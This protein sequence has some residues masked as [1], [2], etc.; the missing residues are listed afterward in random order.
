MIK[1]YERELGIEHKYEFPIRIIA[2]IEK[3][4]AVRNIDE[5]IEATDGVMVA[6]GDL[7]IEMPA[8]DVPLIQKT[9]IDKCLEA[10]K[11]VVVATQMLDSMIRNPRPTRAEVSDI[12]NAVIDHTDAIMLSGETA[13]GKH[14]VEAVATMAT[15]AMETEASVY[16]D[17]DAPCGVTLKKTTEDAISEVANILVRGIKAKLILVASMSGDTARIVS[18]Y[19]PELPIVVATS[20]ER[21][22]RQINLSW[23]VVP[24]ILPRCGT[25]EELV[26]RS[27]GYLKKEK[28]VK[29]GDKIVVV[30][31]E[32]VGMSGGVNLVEIREIK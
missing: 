20:D 2:K 17:L 30:A 27:V 13:N 19:R 21:V 11:P 32:P 6:R 22:N 10:A 8:E 23:G 1:D 3:H 31:G 15:V 16:D 25:V 28:H 7:G 5:I 12:A 4:E 18:R 24:F 29:I 26:D 9:L 14:P